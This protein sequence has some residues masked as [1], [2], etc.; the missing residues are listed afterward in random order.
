MSRGRDQHS[1]TQ[2]QIALGAAVL[3]ML[4]VATYVW[5]STHSGPDGKKSSKQKLVDY[6]SEP[7]NVKKAGGTTRTEAP[8]IEVLQNPSTPAA[9]PAVV[10]PTFSSADKESGAAASADPDKTPQ[11]RNTATTGVETASAVPT[12]SVSQQ[13]EELDKKGKALF[14]SGDVSMPMLYQIHCRLYECAA[15]DSNC[16]MFTC[17]CFTHLCFVV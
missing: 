12:K 6:G 3:T 9:S 17:Y 10:T 4:S 8:K 13:V 1:V 15:S 14:K 11:V 5:W 2:Q 7:S 16:D